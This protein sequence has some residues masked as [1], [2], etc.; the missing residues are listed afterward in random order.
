MKRYG[1]LYHQIT[2]FENLLSASRKARKGKRFKEQTSRFELNL[3]KELFRLQRELTAKTYKHGGYRDFFVYDPKMRLISAAPYRDRVIHHALCNI[4]EPIFD[5]TFI[6]DSYACRKNKGTHKA[7]DRYSEFA[8]KNTYVLKCDIRKYFHGIDH[9]FLFNAVSRKIKCRET[10]WLIRKIIGTRKDNSFICY[11]PGDNLFTPVERPKGI[12][13][14]NLT[15][16]FF[17]NIYLDGFDHFVKEQ[18]KCRYYIRYVDD[19]VVFHKDKKQLQMIKLR[20]EEFLESLRL[21]LHR[22]KSRAYRVSDGVVFL[23]CRMFP[24]HRLLKKE[25]ALGMRRR[26]KKMARQ[27]QNGE[28]PL[29]KVSQRIQS[30][31][32]HARHADTWRLRERLFSEVAFQRGEAKSDSWGGVEQQS[33]QR[34]L[35]R[36]QQQPPEQPEQQCRFPLL[37]DM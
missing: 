17:A 25:N 14:G 6:F 29:E 18:L 11:F 15:S 16:Q 9:E 31:I 32:G 35:C 26:L 5:R 36:P 28:I 7:L 22:D 34:A 24:N 8:R 2:A 37:Q 12:P 33:E 4:I 3:E 27:Y 10:L 20:V 21:R 19:F 30:W 13:I 23:G 1:N